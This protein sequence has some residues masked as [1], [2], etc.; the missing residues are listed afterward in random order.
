MSGK[1]WSKKDVWMGIGITAGL[2]LL[3]FLFMPAFFAIGVVQF[4]YLLPAIFFLR[5]KKGIV[6]GILIG[7]GI[8]FLV[9]CACFGYVITSLGN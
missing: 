9:N 5:Q 7:A 1:S 8:T 6:Q 3:L 4:L 2:H